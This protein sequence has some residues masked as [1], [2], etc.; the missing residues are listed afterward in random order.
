[1]MM[2]KTQLTELLNDIKESLLF[3]EELNQFTFDH[4]GKYLP[5]NDDEMRGMVKLLTY[6]TTKE[7]RGST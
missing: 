2:K 7:A 3:H 4:E 1:M 5:D 6:L